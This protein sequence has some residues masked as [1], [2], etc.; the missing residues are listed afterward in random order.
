MNKN[1]DSLL[2]A[3]K[4]EAHQSFNSILNSKLQELT[5]QINGNKQGAYQ[6]HG[7]CGC[8][9]IFIAFVLLI[10]VYFAK[11]YWEEELQLQE[12]ISFDDPGN[13]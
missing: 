13:C 11:N 1:D 3:E 9:F 6:F 7:R 2:S 4:L 5:E 10:P 12:Y 8:H